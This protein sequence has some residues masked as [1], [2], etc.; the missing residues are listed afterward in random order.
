MLNIDQARGAPLERTTGLA[1]LA[2]TALLSTSVAVGSPGEP[3]LDASHAAAA[4]YVADVDRPWVPPV[5]AVAQLAL[6]VLLWL[7][8]GHALLLRRYEGGQ[9]WG[10]APFGRLHIWVSPMRGGQV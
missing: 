3:E 7:M 8:V 5:A 2:G 6:M 4:A 1:G 9:R 10:R